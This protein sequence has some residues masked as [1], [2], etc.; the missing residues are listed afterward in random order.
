MG[1]AFMSTIDTHINWGASCTVNDLYKRF[2]NPQATQAQLVRA[3]RFA[4]VGILILALIVTTQIATIENAWKFV[5]LIGS[6]MGLTSIL[7]WV[8]WRMN[9]WGELAGIGGGALVS[10]VYLSPWA[11]AWN[12]MAYYQQLLIVVVFTSI[13]TL[14]VVFLTPPESEETLTQFTLK[15]SPRNLDH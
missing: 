7:R 11:E 1:A 10:L 9:A 3:S 6:G 14:V 12:A 8:W 4:T 15:V 5:T 13:L 2:I